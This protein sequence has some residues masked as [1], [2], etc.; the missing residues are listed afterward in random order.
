M[1]QKKIKYLLYNYFKIIK[2]NKKLKTEF[3]LKK[4]K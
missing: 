4:I 3:T 1:F 2:H